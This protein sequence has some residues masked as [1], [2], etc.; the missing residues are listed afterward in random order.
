MWELEGASN[1]GCFRHY[2]PT[3][4]KIMEFLDS[5]LLFN[6][7]LKSNLCHLDIGVDLCKKTGSVQIEGLRHG[8]GGKA[9]AYGLR[10]CVGWVREG[11]APGCN[12]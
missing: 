6:L 7:S 5:Y 3:A 4:D 10:P 11:V 12:L 8:I 9:P 1:P 2:A